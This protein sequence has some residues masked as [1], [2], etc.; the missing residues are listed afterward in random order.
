MALY[1]AYTDGA[2]SPNPGLCG[3]GYVLLN[4]DDEIVSLG[5]EFVCE[6][7]TNNIGEMTG[8]LRV[9]QRFAEL[10]E[11]EGDEE[12]PDK[13]AKTLTVYTDSEVCLKIIKKGSTKIE[14][15]QKILTKIMHY[16]ANMTVELKWVKGHDGV[17]WN[18]LADRLADSS[19]SF[20][21][22][23][24]A[25]TNNAPSSTG[26]G[27]AASTSTSNVSGRSGSTK[28][29]IELDC[30]FREKEEVKK[31][32][33]KWSVSLKKWIVEDS[34]ENRAKFAKWI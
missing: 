19:I 34:F 9:L 2:C 29:F 8:I 6:T 27:S 7:G 15:L 25:S 17:K 21:R 26:T 20:V 33:A 12:G 31:I 32:G 4:S 30:P 1:T 28:T 14:H 10:D 18:E 23:A 3:C 22:A 16:T 11:E 13:A 24:N 5:S